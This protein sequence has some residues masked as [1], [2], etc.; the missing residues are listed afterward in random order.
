ML[1]VWLKIKYYPHRTTFRK[2]GMEYQ[3][4]VT[5]QPKDDDLVFGY[6]SSTSENPKPRHVYNK[7][8]ERF[9]EVLDLVEKGKWQKGGKRDIDTALD[10]AKDA[11][12]F[13]K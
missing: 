9:G 13:S 6:W 1:K 3:Q 7:V 5:P 2:E 8:R 11:G 4:F 12:Y 10:I